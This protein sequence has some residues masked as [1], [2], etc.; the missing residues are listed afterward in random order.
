[1]E[2]SMYQRLE[3]AIKRLAEI[4]EQLMDENVTRD[5]ANFR[6]ISK[7][8][9][10][11]DPQVTLFLRYKKLQ[12]DKEQ[13]LEMAAESDPEIAELGKEELKAIT[14]EE[15]KIIEELRILL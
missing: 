6:A 3:T 5:L 13:A 11:L 12:N 10:I 7:E 8:R 15:P 4:D 14:E 2:E 1:M 9:A